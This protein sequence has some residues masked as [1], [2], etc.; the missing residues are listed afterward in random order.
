MSGGRRRQSVANHSRMSRTS[1]LDSFV[2]ISPKAK[3]V[4]C[5]G[6]LAMIALLR[7]SSAG[8]IATNRYSRQIGCTTLSCRSIDDRRVTRSSGIAEPSQADERITQRLKSALELVDIRV[9][10]HLIIG[11]DTVVSLASRGLL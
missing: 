7:R 2:R 10:D 4:T 5:G 3:S 11:G 1:S 6:V 9:L 8:A